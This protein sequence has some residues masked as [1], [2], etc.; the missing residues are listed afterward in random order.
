MPKTTYLQVYGTVLVHFKTCSH[1]VFVFALKMFA[2]IWHHLVWKVPLKTMGLK[3]TWCVNQLFNVNTYAKTE[4]KLAVLAAMSKFASIFK[5][6]VT[7]E[8]FSVVDN[9]LC[10]FR[11]YKLLVNSPT[12]FHWFS[13]MKLMGLTIII[14]EN[15]YKQI[16]MAWWICII[17]ENF[18]RCTCTQLW[19]ATGLHTA[20]KILFDI[21]SNQPRT[22]FSGT[23]DSG[24]YFEFG[25]NVFSTPNVIPSMLSGFSTEA[26]VVKVLSVS[27]D[28]F[29]TTPGIE[30]ILW[31]NI[32]V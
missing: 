30:H 1:Q 22:D 12:I 3:N 15:H 21:Q 9:S 2:G 4:E 27:H 11:K 29:T 5:Q 32:L 7:Y 26:S 14:I 13:C 17:D 6:S 24:T 23:I 31:Y 20:G 16:D 19:N 28:C 18:C 8:D 25:W 10:A